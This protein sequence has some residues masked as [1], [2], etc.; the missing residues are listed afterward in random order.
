MNFKTNIYLFAAIAVLIGVLVVSQ[1]TGPKKGEEG[2]LLPGVESKDVTR[3]TIERKQPAENKLVFVRTGREQWK[4]EE[5]YEARLDGRQVESLLGG[6]TS[7]KTVTKGA[8]LTNNPAKFGLDRPAVIVALDAGGKTVSVNFGQVTIGAADSSLV[9]VNTSERK[10]PAAVKRSALSALFRDIPDAQTAGDLFKPVSEFRSRDLLL[11]DASFNAV[12]VVKTVRLHGDKGELVLNKTSAGTWQFEKP[13]GYGDADLEGDMSGAGADAA[14]SGVK[15]LLT[16]LAAIRVNSGDDFIENVTDFKQYGLEP[17]KAAGPRIEVVR[18]GEGQDAPP[19][20]EVVT[21]GKK[22]EKGD[23]VYVRPGNENAVAKVPAVY[24]EPIRKLIENPSALRSRA[25]LPNGTAGVDALNI[26][27]GGDPPIELR[28]LP[29]GWKLFG[30]NEPK[31]ANTQAIQ[32]LLTELGG[33]RLVRDF[34]DP[35]LT[36]ADKGFDRPSAVVTLWV[37]GIVEEPKPEE[38]KDAKKAG[39]EQQKPPEKKD[40]P[41][42]K[43]AKKDEKP[44]EKKDEKKEPARP[45]MKEPTAKLIFGKRDKDLLYVRREMGGTK[46]DFAVPESLLPKLTRGRLDYLDQVL[47]SFTQDQ[48]T[49]LTF[50]R[51]GET[52]AVEKETKDKAPPT[53]VIHQPANLAGRPAEPFK[54]MAL[55]GD[56]SQLRAERL[57]AEKATD[58]ELERFGLKAPRLTATVTLA[59]AKDK[60][61]SY[62]FGAETDDKT[63][64]YAKQGDRDLVFSVPKSVVDAFQQADVV[65]PTVFRVDLS[66][67]T[68]MKL[69]GWATLN[70]E[71]KPQTLDLERKGANNWAVKA[72]PTFKLSASQAE[73]LLSA[74]AVVQAEKVVVY[75]TGPKPEHKL[76]PADGALAIEIA[77]DGEKQPVTLTIG[78]E[79]EGGKSY[80]AQ[81]NKTPGDVFL[82]PKDRFEKFKANPNAFAAE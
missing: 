7:A 37:N 35:K 51:G 81:S 65:D 43:A 42:D 63:R 24:I 68:G 76:T 33:R 70:V 12:E 47:P 31:S 57:W 36:D 73:S 26:R 74:L 67:V 69:S 13:A 75:K 52:W 40:E 55:L 25:L 18:K 54:V 15:P 2:K 72:P 30:P 64:V 32:G 29:D 79:A 41:K 62:L 50:I 19:V 46:A 71:R 58:K 39:E 45:K 28:K 80:Y 77:V 10:E 20:T 9:Y 27:V 1:L 4:L 14:P 61:R 82:V 66:K 59:D 34:P 11:A 21:V 6:L 16:A 56:L 60:E 23:K 78:A 5:P 22:E 48:V 3:V 8:D 38:K 53:W 17:G 44:A 49:K